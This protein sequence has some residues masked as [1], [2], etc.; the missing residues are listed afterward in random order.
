MEG[1]TARGVTRLRLLMPLLLLLLRGGI[2]YGSGSFGA[3]VVVFRFYGV[4]RGC[5]GSGSTPR[6]SAGFLLPTRCDRSGPV[7]RKAAA[8][9]AATRQRAGERGVGVVL[10]LQKKRGGGVD[11]EGMPSPC[12]CAILLHLDLF[13]LPPP[14][15]SSSLSLSGFR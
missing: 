3:T 7:A 9:G 5:S 14:A 2:F 13:L 11:A 4:P 15:P 10:M 6:S 12:A 8:T 1:G